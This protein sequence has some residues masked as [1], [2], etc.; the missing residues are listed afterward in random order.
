VATARRFARWRRRRTWLLATLVISV[1]ATATAAAAAAAAEAG[2]VGAPPR[3]WESARLMTPASPPARRHGAQAVCAGIDNCGFESGFL[4]AWVGADLDP[5]LLPLQVAL[6]GT[7][8]GLG[9]FAC[10]PTD[11][12]YAIVTGFDGAGPGI[13]Q[14][15]QDLANPISGSLLVFDY[16]AAWD[17][18][19][20]G[21]GTLPRTFEVAIEPVG[22]GA[23]LAS[24]VVL[25]AMPQ[26]RVLDTGPLIHA[27]PVS[28][29]AGQ[30]VRVAFR[31]HVPQY[32]TGPGFFQ[33]D[34]VRIVNDQLN[35]EPGSGPSRRLD[36]RPV[37]PNPSHEAVTFAFLLPD[38]GDVEL[39]IVDVRGARV[40][41]EQRTGMPAGEHRLSWSGRSSDGAL[42][43]AGI[44]HARVRTPASSTS[45]MFVRIR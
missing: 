44:Y 3:Y 14:L 15:H 40:W 18:V 42:A 31:W 29:F 35:V 38:A 13:I 17:L 37:M 45:R 24:A 21:G 12:S 19:T 7:S 39:E 4:P 11:G 6:A 27:L 36:L 10:T 33:L 41:S 43:P 22:G 9:M 30:F 25:T 5:P 2:R 28:A 32:F 16:R 23:P 26:T 1:A 8:P 20:F 34:R